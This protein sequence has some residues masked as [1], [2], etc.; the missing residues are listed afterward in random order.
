MALS[1]LFVDKHIAAEQARLTS[2]YYPHRKHWPMCLFHHAPMENAIAI[3]RDGN[4]RARSDAANLLP[5]D[6][7][8]PGVIDT[9]NDAHG[10][11]R[12]YFRPKT[13]T[14]WNIEGIRKPGECKYGDATHAGVLVMFALNA[15]TV[16]TKLGTMFSDKN[17]QLAGTV[18]GIS[19][20]YF[21]SI[22]FKKVYSEGGTG[23]DHS[24]IDIRAA[25]VLAESPLSLDECLNFIYLRSEPERETLLHALGDARDTWAPFCQVSDALKVFQKDYTFVQELRITP[26]GVV[27]R[28]N[29]RRDGQNIKIQI[30]VFDQ[31][32]S[33]VGDFFNNDHPA[34]PNPPAVNWIWEKKWKSGL[35]LIEIELEDTIAYRANVQLGDTLF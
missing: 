29:P 32:G 7:A 8:A 3:L 13:P 16:L 10:R 34:H 14:Q 22:D 28:L 12:I 1:E 2:P 30:R 15:K 35:Y 27:F 21:S 4:L 18:P 23:G 24:V 11:V 19:E 20:A 9:R 31:H 6:V 26:K 5:R 25:E 17:M 33:A